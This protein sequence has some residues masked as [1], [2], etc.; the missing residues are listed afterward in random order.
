MIKLKL[1]TMMFL[2]YFIWGVWFVTMGTYLGQTLGFDDQQIEQF[3]IEFPLFCILVER[4]LDLKV[5]AEKRG[6][7]ADYDPFRCSVTF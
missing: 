6:S 3:G 4:G 5:L 2:Q 1:G 7:A